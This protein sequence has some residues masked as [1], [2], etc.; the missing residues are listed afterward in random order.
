MKNKKPA[1]VSNA[2]TPDLR[3][4]RQEY[5]KKRKLKASILVLIASL[6][7]FAAA[8]FIFGFMGTTVIRSITIE[9]GDDMVSASDFFEDDVRAFF[10]SKDEI[11]TSKPGEYELTVR[12]GILFYHVTL[13]IQDTVP[14]EAKP[15]Q[16]R[17]RQGNGQVS[18]MDFVKS[19]SDKTEVTAEFE[20][21]PDFN[22]AGDSNVNVILSDLGGNTT[23]IE[24]KITV[25]P[26]EVSSSVTVEAGYADLSVR[27][28]LSQDAQEYEGDCIVTE[29]GED[30]FHKVGSTK[31]EIM[32]CS[33]VYTVTVTVE[34]TKPPAGY[35]INRTT[36]KGV[37][38]AA[39]DFV[40]K[41]YDETK[42]SV[43]YTEEPNFDEVGSKVLEIVLEDGGKNTRTYNVTLT[44]IAD[45][46]KPIISAEDRTVYIGDNIRFSEGVT[47]TDNCDGELEVTVDIG[48]FDRETPG[49]YP[50]K[51][52]ATDKSG[53][54]AEKTVNFT[55]KQKYAYSYT[56]EVIDSL[57]TSVFNEIV[58]EHMT[59]KDKMRAIYDYVRENISYNGTSE[60]SDWEQEAYR[61]LR[62]KQ[63][64]SFTFYAIS[65]KLLTMAGI[66]NKEVQRINSDSS[67]YWNMVLYNG[68]WY[69]FDTCPHYKDYPI[70]S[71]MLTDKEAADY[72]KLTG[73]YYTYK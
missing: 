49:T 68:E 10:V 4:K 3:R 64:D 67:H 18:A 60:K 52:T 53:N 69:H 28:F 16:V 51:F 22:K 27:D 38:I 25:F 73:G 61:G 26:E 48:D 34:D 70:D 7:L 14:P 31:I 41:F 29:V 57:F 62:S 17:I 59:D 71:F 36:Y 46:E 39:E 63:G 8:V 24:S 55:L 21:P 42:V 32:Y 9:A 40:K 5:R 13:N 30:L 15:K 58:N 20:T 35:I 37:P 47:A 1:A 43:S 65:R 12:N 23:R 11:D 19:V 66:E 6:L 44:V 50:I 54:T 72:S 45:T 33:A 56:Q 2:F